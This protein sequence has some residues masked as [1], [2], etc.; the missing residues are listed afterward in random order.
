[1][2][3]PNATKK[4]TNVSINQDLLKRARALKINLSQ[5]LEERLVDLLREARRVQWL[6]NN[7][8]ALA[9]YERYVATHGVFSEK[10]RGF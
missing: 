10:V 3:D 8:K 5:A 4:A 2:F 9:D 1:M 7:R 6:T